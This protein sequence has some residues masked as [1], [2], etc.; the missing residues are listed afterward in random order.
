MKNIIIIDTESAYVNTI[1]NMDDISVELMVVDHPRYIEGCE[2][3]AKGKIKNYFCRV[4]TYDDEFYDV[5]KCNYNL[6]LSDIEKYRNTQYKVE[7]YLARASSDISLMQSQYYIALAYV[8]NFFNTHKI[9]F[10]FHAYL[11]H[12]GTWDTL[13]MD[14]ARS[15]NIPVYVS[16]ISSS[17]LETTICTL[18]K[19]TNDKTFFMDLS[20]LHFSWSMDEYYGGLKSYTDSLFASKFKKFED[21]YKDLKDKITYLKQQ[22]Y[23]TFFSFDKEYRKK[24]Q[25]FIYTGIFYKR[26]ELV[27]KIYIKNLE[28]YYRELSVTP[29]LSQNYI[30][31]PLHQEPE[32][33]I[34]TRTPLNSQFYIIYE[35]AQKLPKGWKVL[36]KEH[37][38]QFTVYKEYKY[39]YRNIE[40]FRSF[41]MYKRLYNL[42]N[43]E[44]VKLESSSSELI[45]NSRAVASIAGSSLLEAVNLDKPIIIF[46]KNCS[47]I[48]KLKDAFNINSLYD[49]VVALSKIENGFI[50]NYLDFTDVLNRY[51]FFTDFYTKEFYCKEKEIFKKI[52]KKCMDDCTSQSKEKE[53]KQ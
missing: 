45:K 3:L 11:E 15:R 36:V 14:V 16:N 33:S 5:T 52:M 10:V 6:T 28:K 23:E 17:T 26:E 30:Y 12:G 27:K 21:N 49:I 42:D 35:L 2:A 43:V 25:R 51:A 41:E 39:Y 19:C 40:F 53:F 18:N 24:S 50:P 34:M 29:D 46:G 7:R 22:I 32:A 38:A 47:F 4:Y 9:D 31:Y 8:I 1:S 48:E 37:P 20:D 13:I 44:L